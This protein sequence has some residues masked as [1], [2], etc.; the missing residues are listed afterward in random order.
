MVRETLITSDGPLSK[1]ALHLEITDTLADD[2]HARARYLTKRGNG[3]T[4]YWA[5]HS[6]TGGVGTIGLDTTARDG[7]DG[8]FGS[9]IQVARFEKDTLL[10]SCT[11][12]T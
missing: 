5:W 1:Y 12:W 11:D 6:N 4:R 2:H 7:E 8:I 9:G 3:T 10:N